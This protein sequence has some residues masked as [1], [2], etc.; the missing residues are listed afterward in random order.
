MA[1]NE[2][3]SYEEAYTKFNLTLIYNNKNTT[4]KVN[5]NKPI[6]YI[7]EIAYNIFYPINGKIQLIYRNKDLTPFEQI[8]IIQY[9]KNLNKATIIIK[10]LNEIYLESNITDLDKSNS[11][12]NETEIIDIEKTDKNRMMCVDCKNTFIYYYCRNCNCFLCRNCKE[13]YDSFHFNHKSC[14]INPEN[15]TECMRLYIK[16]LHEEMAVL[17]RDF[18]RFEK[19]NKNIVLRDTEEWKEET[20]SKLN[21]LTEFTQKIEEE[22]RKGGEAV[23]EN[24]DAK[25]VVENMYNQLLNT[26]PE[27]SKNIEKS[28]N[29]LKKIDDEIKN[30]SKKIEECINLESQKT[31]VDK[32]FIPLNS[33]LDD[34]IKKLLP[35]KKTE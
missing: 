27:K 30:I 5:N 31:K 2:N 22:T 25:E 29:S 12:V 4:V 26:N 7:R 17:K 35:E 20:L 24:F 6:V 21:S 18:D 15:L 28:F 34:I 1:N 8:P 23:K 3:E 32:I 10:P 19:E 13:R 9:F 33:K 16:N 11:K 14:I